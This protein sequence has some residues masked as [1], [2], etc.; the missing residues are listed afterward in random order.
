NLLV[1]LIG[2]VD[3]NTASNDDNDYDNDD[4]D[5]IEQPIEAAMGITNPPVNI[6]QTMP[7][8]SFTSARKLLREVTSS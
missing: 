2:D 7:I 1:N 4:G 8:P 3:T 5:D 6:T